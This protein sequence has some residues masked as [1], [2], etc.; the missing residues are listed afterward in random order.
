MIVFDWSM[1]M[2]G[3]DGLA[4][5]IIHF[6]MFM[7]VDGRIINNTYIEYGKGLEHLQQCI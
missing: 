4:H 7:G 2:I 6:F 1:L 3:Q 5:W